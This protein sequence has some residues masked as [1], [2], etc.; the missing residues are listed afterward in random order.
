VFLPCL[1]DFDVLPESPVYRAREAHGKTRR[2]FIEHEKGKSFVTAEC[3]FVSV[4]KVVFTLTPGNS[5]GRMV[6]EIMGVYRAQ[7]KSLEGQPSF[8]E[9]GG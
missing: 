3:S 6:I 8:R 7:I 1:L 4:W 5:Y 2:D 9:L